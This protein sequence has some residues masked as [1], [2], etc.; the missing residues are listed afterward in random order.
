[1][2]LEKISIQHLRLIE[3]CVLELSPGFNFFYGANG[4]GK[5][6]VLEA[7]ALVALCKS[8]RASQAK[9]IIS[10]GQGACVVNAR[11]DDGSSTGV[12][13]GIEGKKRL[14][15]N[16][17]D[18]A[19]ASLLAEQCPILLLDNT[20]FELIDGGPSA[21]REI[22]DWGVFH[23]EHAF[24]QQWKS[25]ERANKQKNT[26][27]KLRRPYQ[28]SLLWDKQIA[29]L[30]EVIH[31]YRCAFLEG[32]IPILKKFCSQLLP[33]FSLSF[34]YYAGWREDEGHSLEAQL[35]NGYQDDIRR[36]YSGCGANRA[37]LNFYMN[38]QP[39]NQALSRGQKKLFLCALKMAQGVHLKQHTDKTCVYLLDDLQSELDKDSWG[40][41]TTAL[42][43]HKAQLLVTGV[44]AP[45]T[46]VM[47]FS[48]A[49]RVFHVEHGAVNVAA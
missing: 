46:D 7:C 45:N 43:H 6:S 35:R 47:D 2:A 31:D 10:Y 16:S 30:S 40:A 14:R 41:V 29:E 17:S 48:R 38:E 42:E 34:N 21:R 39:V 4:S 28:E 11:H 19:S 23:V 36:G 3:Q 20:S 1:M 13:W 15:K 49:P 12:E 24:K 9:H 27:L 37:R 32:F 26:L 22:L 44:D 33:R 8:F 25:L 5:T 18:V